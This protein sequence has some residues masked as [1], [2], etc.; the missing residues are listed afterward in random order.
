MRRRATIATGMLSG[1]FLA[2]AA[3]A[4]DLGR[5]EYLEY[6]AACHGA[7]GAGDGPLA[8]MIEAPVPP[9]T[10]L[11]QANG[12]R[13]PMLRVIRVIDGRQ[14]VPGHGYPMPVW[15]NRLT[16]DTGDT[17]DYPVELVVRGRILSLAYYLESIQE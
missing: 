7:A 9:L 6:C 2:G 13:F 16:E 5:A 15:G 17:G 12:G 1:L 4:E 14:E 3:A 10:G 11:S 8:E